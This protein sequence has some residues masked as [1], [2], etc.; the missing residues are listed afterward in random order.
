MRKVAKPLF[1]TERGQILH[2]DLLCILSTRFEYSQ[3]V[4]DI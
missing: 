4:P 1:Q 3:A 2:A